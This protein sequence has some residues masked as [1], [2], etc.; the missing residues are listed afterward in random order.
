MYRKALAVELRL[1]GLRVQ[2]EA[3]IDVFYKTIHVGHF[4]VD[5]LVE[6]R[7]ALE[8]KASATLGPTDKDQTLNLLSSSTLDVGLLLHYGPSPKFFRFVSPRVLE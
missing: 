4:R 3:P 2:E 1:R 5:L 8:L 6:E 7:V